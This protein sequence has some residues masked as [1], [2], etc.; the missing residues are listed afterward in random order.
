MPRWN[1]DYYAILEVPPDADFTALKRAYYR[2]AKECHPDRH[3][4]RAEKEEEFKRLVEAFDVLSDPVRRRQFDQFHQRRSVPAD[5]PLYF[6]TD[7]DETTVMDSPADDTLE[8]LI[9]GN[10]IPR[11]ST[12]QTLMLD[13][14]RTEQFCLYREA[15]TCLFNGDFRRASALFERAAATAPGNILIRFHAAES[16]SRIG[17][18]RRALEHLEIAVQLGVGRC[19]PQRLERVRQLLHQLHRTQGGLMQRWTAARLPE[20]AGLDEPPDAAMRR[21]LG[22]AMNRLQQDR[23]RNRRALPE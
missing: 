22:R 21:Q 10:T 19:P 12:L 15:K 17:Q 3:Q 2:R 18:G 9:V 4:G 20:V 14:E 8:E 11:H 5:E 1:T 7:G 13:L 6:F 16:L 23:T